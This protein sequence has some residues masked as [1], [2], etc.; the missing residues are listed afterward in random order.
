VV[1]IASAAV[2]LISGAVKSGE[3]RKRDLFTVGVTSLVFILLGYAIVHI[4]ANQPD[5]VSRL[6]GS[7]AGRITW[8]VLPLVLLLLAGLYVLPTYFQW[9]RSIFG[10]A[11]WLS[12]I[13]LA[14]AQVHFMFGSGTPYDLH[15][16][17]ANILKLIGYMV[18]LAGLVLD[19][20]RTYH[21]LEEAN[22]SL[23]NELLMFE[24]SQD[25]SRRERSFLET[26]L[27]TLPDPVC[28]LDS[29]L[30]VARMNAAHTQ[31]I[32]VSSAFGAVG[33]SPEAFWGDTTGEA[34]LEACRQVLESGETSVQEASPDTYPD[35]LEHR[36][37]WILSPVRDAKE[38]V[39]AIVC[40]A[41][42]AAP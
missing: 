21:G 2:F 24:Q 40:I 11:L 25:S 13:P 34:R 33:K 19:Y 31:L 37:S 5:L 9:H 26:L 18:P 39:V 32:A 35:G 8:N 38:Q 7:K 1:L 10:H 22:K 15:F 20:Q 12:C 4:C 28:I 3:Q 36:F 17:T 27:T 23:R 14:L 6:Y 29:S 42:E 41:R 16:Q 30:R